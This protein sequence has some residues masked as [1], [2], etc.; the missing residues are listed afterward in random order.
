MRMILYLLI[1][2]IPIAI[3]YSRFL[4][5]SKLKEFL[6]AVSY[7]SVMAWAFFFAL[8]LEMLLR[9]P[10]KYS[11][12]ILAIVLAYVH[13]RTITHLRKQRGQD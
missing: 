6:L 13:Y 7:L 2:L 11:V 5:G 8:I 3:V 9:I 12:A 10:L 1:A 4:D